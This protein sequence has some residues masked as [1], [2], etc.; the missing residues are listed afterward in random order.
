[1]TKGQL[2]IIHILLVIICIVVLSLTIKKYVLYSKEINM[3]KIIELS[4]SQLMEINGGGMKE[5]IVEYV[6]GLLV[7]YIVGTPDDLKQGYN[8]G[9][10]R[11]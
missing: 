2:L 3:E 1:M 5:K 11:K 7:D 9:L 6:V 4:A 10:K 8:D